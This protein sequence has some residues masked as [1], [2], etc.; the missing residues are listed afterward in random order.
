MT[1]ARQRARVVEIARSWLG[2]PYHH[3]ARVKGAGVDCAQILIAVFA[4]A[5]LVEPFDVGHYPHDWMLHR[6]E[7]R[8]LDWVM[9]YCPHEVAGEPR[10]GDIAVWRWGR[11]FSHGGIVTAW[12]ELVHAYLPLGC[13][14]LGDA[15]EGELGRRERR[16]F[17]FW[18]PRA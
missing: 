6:D 16:V 15:L 17:S 8:Y 7:E 1:E 4:E 18:E 3:Q 14:A 10:P 2:T 11:C 5:G 13:V 12:P 9:R